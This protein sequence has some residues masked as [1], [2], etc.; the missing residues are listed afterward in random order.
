MHPMMTHNADSERGETFIRSVGFLDE[1]E[2]ALDVIRTAKLRAQDEMTKA[3]ERL[4]DVV[5]AQQDRICGGFSQT[6]EILWEKAQRDI[7]LAI[8]TDVE[9][10]AYHVEHAIR[11]EQ[12]G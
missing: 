3:I 2:D 10:I 11:A 6:D 5:A 7:M 12:E 8:E 4:R 9:E 1:C